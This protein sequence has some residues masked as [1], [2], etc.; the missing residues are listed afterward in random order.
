MKLFVT[1]ILVF[2]ITFFIIEKLFYIFIYI[3]PSL[4]IDKRLEYVINGDMNKDLIILGSSRGARNIIAS[5]IED[6]LNIESYNLSYPGSNIVFHEFLLRSLVTYNTPPKIVL[7]ALD[8]SSELLPSESLT[9]RFDRLYPLAKYDYI[10]QEM[11][12]RGE[13]N[14]LSNFF[15]LSNIN[16]R[17]LDIRKKRF[18][19]LDTIMSKGSMPISFQRENRDFIFHKSTHTYDVDAELSEKLNAFI[20]FQHLCISNG[21]QLFLL[22]SPNF[23]EHNKAFENRMSELSFPSVSSIMYDTSN[24]VYK[25]SDYF[26]DEGHL[27]KNG[28][29]IFTNEIISHLKDVVRTN[30]IINEQ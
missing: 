13:R 18:S 12:E 19:K 11:I 20:S 10:H 2:S 8:D 28:A 21:I 30:H 17:N 9:F 24:A 3:S 7:L 16:I 15:I 4:E 14:L 27:K 1:K 23:W 22:Y 29:I 26:Y 6:S 5:Q 25:N